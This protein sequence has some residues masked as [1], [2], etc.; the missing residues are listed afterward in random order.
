MHIAYSDKPVSLFDTGVIISDGFRI[1][2]SYRCLPI[3]V[4]PKEGSP[5]RV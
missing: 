4:K 3:G 1:I 5:D 2:D